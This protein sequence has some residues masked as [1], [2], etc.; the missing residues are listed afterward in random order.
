MIARA[1]LLA[2]AGALAGCGASASSS[3]PATSDAAPAP[4]P[5]AV[6]EARA[7][8]EALFFGRAGCAT[9]HMVGERGDQVRGPNLGV[10]GRQTEPLARRAAKRRPGARPIVHA[11]ESI[12]DPTALTIEGYGEGVM[13][14]GDEPPIALT[15]DE[16]VALAAFV[17]GD[18]LTE[19]DLVAARAAC[20]P[21]KAARRQR[22]AD[23]RLEGA[24][25][26]VPWAAGDARAGAAVWR[27]LQ[28][29][30]CHDNPRHP[31]PAPS[32]GGVG[33]RLAPADIARWIIA[34]PLGTRMPSYAD[35]VE[36]EDLAH[37]TAYVR[38]R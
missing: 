29:G 15:D 25:A 27:R 4:E 38:S 12:L 32:L 17:V 33:A 14:P 31:Q 21:A 7:A 3:V 10:G 8:G 6:A 37:L 19:A 5:A 11:V 28:C 30:L 34:P 9:C 2:A 18:G 23:Q 22:A 1:V 26:R 13:K 24:L 16:V 20:G 36:G 35:L